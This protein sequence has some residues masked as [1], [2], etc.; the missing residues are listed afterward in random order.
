MQVIHRHSSAT[1]QY[2]LV[3]ATAYQRLVRTCGWEGNC[4]FGTPWSCV[5]DLLLVK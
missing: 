5:T 2:N 1:K 4:R 3:K